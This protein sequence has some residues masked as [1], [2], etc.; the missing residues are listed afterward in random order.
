MDYVTLAWNVAFRGGGLYLEGGTLVQAHLTETQFIEN[1]ASE[2]KL[3]ITN[4]DLLGGARGG[5]IYTQAKLRMTSATFR[6][7]FA[8]QGGGGCMPT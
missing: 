4:N 5:G 6:S 1:N 7:N 3:Q 8:Q 2:T